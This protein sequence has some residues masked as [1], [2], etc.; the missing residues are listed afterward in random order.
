MSGSNAV[1]GRRRLMLVICKHKE[2][3]VHKIKAN[4]DWVPIAGEWHLMAHFLDG[5]V[6]KNWRKIYQPIALH[7]DIKGLQYKLIMKHASIRLRWT[8]IIGMQA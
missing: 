4:N 8:M 1:L 2:P 6:R 5:M 3:L 7:F